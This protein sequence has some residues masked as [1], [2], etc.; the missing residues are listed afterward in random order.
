MKPKNHLK[1]DLRD[2]PKKSQRDFKLLIIKQIF[3]WMPLA[4][5]VYIACFSSATAFAKGIQ[6]ATTK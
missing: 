5:A 2:M 1:K 3:R 6:H 4:K